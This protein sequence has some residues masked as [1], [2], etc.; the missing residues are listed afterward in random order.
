ML[1][2]SSYEMNHECPPRFALL[3]FA[4]AYTHARAVIVHMEKGEEPQVLCG[5]HEVEFS[6]YDDWLSRKLVLIFCNL[7]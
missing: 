2:P 6:Y 7:S 1:Y 3:H 4:Y 5:L